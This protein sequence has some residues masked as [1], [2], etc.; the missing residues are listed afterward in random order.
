VA[1]GLAGDH[2]TGGS[3]R[4]QI[5]MIS[6]DILNALDLAPGTISENVVI[7]GLDVMKLP[8]GRRYRLGGALV[9]VTI[10]CEPC[11]QM[12]RIRPG[13]QAALENRRGMFL[14]VLTPGLVRVGD[15]LEA[16]DA[17]RDAG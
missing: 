12:E 6:S 4:R 11:I 5:L 2:H 17:D 7:D 8:E 1:G 10:P 9:E 3:K 15:S 13:L 14:K 16:A